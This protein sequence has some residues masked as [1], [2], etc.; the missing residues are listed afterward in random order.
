[1]LG[2]LIPRAPAAGSLYFAARTQ[3][4][5]AGLLPA[6]VPGERR[7]VVGLSRPAGRRPSEAAKNATRRPQAGTGSTGA[8]PR[9]T[10]GARRPFS[11][12]TGGSRDDGGSGHRSGPGGE[13]S[14]DRSGPVLLGAAVCSMVGGGL[15]YYY[16]GERPLPSRA[17]RKLGRGAAQG[18]GEV[19]A[20]QTPIAEP[21][22]FEHPLNERPLLVR[23][24]LIARRV[25]WLVIVFTPFAV[26]SGLLLLFNTTAARERWI[27]SLVSSLE[28]A[29]C[30]FQKFGQ[31]MS[32]RPDMLPPDVI[33]ALSKLRMDVPTHSMAHNDAVIFAG[34]GMHIP[35]IFSSFDELPVASGTVAQV[36]RAVLKPAFSRSG[37]PCQVTHHFHTFH[38]HPVTAV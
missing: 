4:L 13:T 37:A 33:D 12:S 16:Y 19:R 18:A 3:R 36:H 17:P 24:W 8:G 11:V 2:P 6:G 26:E 5:I 9:P 34:T 30:S 38:L 29:G 7:T 25:C 10:D 1:M 23:W 28:S 27:R 32:M 20:G 21:I 35:E 15:Y 14:G 31:W 22:R